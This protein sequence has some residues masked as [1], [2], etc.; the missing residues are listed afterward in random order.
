MTDPFGEWL[1]SLQSGVTDEVWTAVGPVTTTP[2]RIP[3]A[4]NGV[5]YCGGQEW[6]PDLYPML[7]DRWEPRDEPEWL[8]APSADSAHP[9]TSQPYFLDLI[10]RID[11]LT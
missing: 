8:I 7:P 6:T 2:V 5:Y 1:N 9:D 10:G 3:P 4:G 11:E